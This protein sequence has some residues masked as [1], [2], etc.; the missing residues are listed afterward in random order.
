MIGGVGK[1]MSDEWEILCFGTGFWVWE[2]K[3]FWFGSVNMCAI[4]RLVGSGIW[5][6]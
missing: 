1:R 2:C 5:A 3:V 6:T 4:A